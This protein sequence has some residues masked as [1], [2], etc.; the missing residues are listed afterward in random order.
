MNVPKDMEKDLVALLSSL[1]IDKENDTVSRLNAQEIALKE[2]KCMHP[3]L[4]KWINDCD[5]P[6]LIE[7]LVLEDAIFFGEFPDV[8]LTAEERKEFANALEAHCE[9]CAHCHLKRAYDLEWQS[10]VNRAFAENKQVI[11]KAIAH[12]AGKK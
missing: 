12:A 8:K 4:G 7:T 1:I 9:N 6:F 11:G 5:F 3:E 10:R 2:L